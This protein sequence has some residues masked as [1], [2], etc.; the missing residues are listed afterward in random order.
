MTLVVP[1]I[2]IHTHLFGC[3]TPEDV[4]TMGRDRLGEQAGALDWY[5]AEYLAATGRKVDWRKYWQSSAG[6]ELL[7][8]DFLLRRPASFAVFQAKFNLLIALFPLHPETSAKLMRHVARRHASDGLSAVEYRT[9]LPTRFSPREGADYLEQLTSVCQQVEREFGGMF[10]PRLAISLPRPNSEFSDRYRL[11][12]DWLAANPCL[13]AYINGIDLCGFEEPDAPSTKIAVFR[14]LLDDN[15]HGKRLHILHHVGESFVGLS[16]ASA[17]RR[18]Y[19][20]AAAGADRLGHALALGLDPALYRQWVAAEDPGEAAYHQSWLAQNSG[21]L[22]DF[23]FRPSDDGEDSEQDTRSLQDALMKKLQTMPVVIESCPTSNYLI[24]A[25]PHHQH[26]LRRFLQ[27]GLKVILSTDD[28]GI[29]A[30]DLEKE[31]V[32]AREQIGCTPDQMRTVAQTTDEV[33][34]AQLGLSRNI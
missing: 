23:G 30:T 12:R 24:S 9:I 7:R 25:Q 13:A 2:D 29:M 14:Q 21:W 17:A 1:R 8:D 28:P 5:A 19:E 16:L 32:I 4:W 10:E 26:P 20:A 22:S 3:L 33:A 6:L 34:R 11:L 27:N 18:V 15:R 31:Y